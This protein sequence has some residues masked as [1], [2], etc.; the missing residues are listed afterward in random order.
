MKPFKLIYEVKSGCDCI[1][2]EK[3]GCCCE[4]PNRTTYIKAADRVAAQAIVAEDYPADTYIIHGLRELPWFWLN[5]YNVQRC[6]GGPEEG[7]WYY[8]AGELLLSVPLLDCI[9]EAAVRAELEKEYSNEGRYP[10]Y[11]VLSDG[12]YRITRSFEQGRNYPEERPHYE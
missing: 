8:D 9:D 2:V 6:Y 1:E 4:R 3:Y 12:A 7:G 10:A 5:V 11:S